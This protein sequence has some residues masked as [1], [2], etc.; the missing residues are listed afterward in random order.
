MPPAVCAGL[1]LR[2]DGRYL[3]IKRVE[4][5]QWE[6]PGGHVEG[7]ET[8][9]Q[10]AL[11]EAIEEVGPFA[12]GPIRQVK[13]FTD[14]VV[15]YTTFLADVTQFT[16]VLSEEHTA[17][18]WFAP[19]DLPANTHPQVVDTIAKL[20]TPARNEL[21]IA[22]DMRDG[23]L[24]SPQQ[25]MNVWLFDLRITG[26]GT[27]VR[28][29]K[30]PK[31][32]DGTDGPKIKEFAHRPVDVFVSDDFI[33]RCNGLSVVFIHPEKSIL[34]TEEFRERVI[35]SVF[36]PY[37]KNEEAWGIAKIYDDDAAALMQ[38][39]HTSTSP[40]VLTDHATNEKINLPDGS[41]VL[42]EGVPALLDHIAVVDAGVWDKGGEPTGIRNDAM[43]EPEGERKY[44][45]VKFADPANDKYPIDTEEHIRAAWDYIHKGNDSDKYSPA[46]LAAIKGR[47]VAAWKDKINPDGP[48]EANS[49][50]DSIMADE[51]PDARKD[52]EDKI[53]AKLDAMCARM[54]ALE[55]QKPNPDLPVIDKK[56]ADG[57][58]DSDTEMADKA[59]R[60]AEAADEKAKKDAA[61]MEERMK[62]D[63]V[64]KAALQAE[65]NALRAQMT[66]AI[67]M[68][69][70]DEMDALAD[71]QAR[72][73]SVYSALGDRASA[74]I[75]GERPIAYRKRLAAKIQHHS[76]QFGKAALDVL[77][78]ATFQAV[79]SAIYA[80]AMAAALSPATAPKTG[81]RAVT[82]RS[83]TG[84]V[85]T[86]YVG[87]VAHFIGK[88]RPPVNQRVRGWS[89]ANKKAN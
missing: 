35:G 39:T 11:R 58:G 60:D 69:S 4:N 50:K 52:A 82:K 64:D 47:I 85:T 37:V 88:Y 86:E 57:N 18:G 89:D 56:D 66:A 26:T 75:H 80:D 53:M 15:D 21:D 54:D 77:D 42:V 87:D 22:R 6:Q 73:D 7:G 34:N 45:D 2:A 14:D 55:A 8:P 74:P 13:R 72:A 41:T 38:T 16:P 40:G 78:D 5:G 23:K 25:F 31:N 83:E 17:A 19:G 84:H 43:S 20:S 24:P 36:L 44:G 70:R 71:A 33:E 68:P 28:W 27:S 61:D 49:R 3:L 1:V 65:I 79:E 62:Q 51:A 63:A 29:V 12:P 59:K 9:E 76:A 46:D 67:T 48:P 30:G 10:A 32:A 81:L